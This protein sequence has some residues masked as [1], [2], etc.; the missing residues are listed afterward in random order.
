MTKQKAGTDRL[1]LAVSWMRQY[2]EHL[3]CPVSQRNW[4]RIQISLSQLD[5][6]EVD[7]LLSEGLPFA[8]HLRPRMSDED[9]LRI[10]DELGNL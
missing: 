9:I 6:D 2:T 4:K 1:R 8:T 10:N 5:N 7:E 3:A